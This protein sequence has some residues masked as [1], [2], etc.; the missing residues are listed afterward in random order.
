LSLQL[1]RETAFRQLSSAYGFPNPN[2]IPKILEMLLTLEE[3]NLLL[4]LPGTSKQVAEKMQ[5]QVSEVEKLLRGFSRKVSLSI[6]Q[7]VKVKLDIL[8]V[9]I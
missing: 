1:S 5:A 7:I 8:F 9:P 3:A 6:H 4:A 2:Y